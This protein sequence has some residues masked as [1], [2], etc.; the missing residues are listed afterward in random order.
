MGDEPPRATP[1]PRSELNTRSELTPPSPLAARN[2]WLHRGAASAAWSLAWLSI[3]AALI[4]RFAGPTPA[5]EGLPFYSSDVY[6]WL[7]VLVGAVNGPV[8]ALL[9]ARTFHPVAWISAACALGFSASA[10]CQSWAI[11][12]FATGNLPAVGFAA[13]A[14][15]WMWVAPAFASVLCLPW[16]LQPA[17]PGKSRRRIILAGAVTS[18]LLALSRLVL[19]DPSTSALPNPLSLA[20]APFYDAIV[21]AAIGLLVPA[22]VLGLAAMVH[23]IRQAAL[24]PARVRSAYR[25]VVVSLGLLLVTVMTVQLVSRATLGALFVV[26]VALLF[27]AQVLYPTAVIVLVLRSRLWGLDVTVSRL[28][29]WAVFTGLTVAC[30][31]ALLW[32][33]GMLLPTHGDV[34]Q[35]ASIAVLAVLLHPLRVH[36]QRTV[37]AMVYGP[38]SDPAVLIA[39]LGAQVEA[40]SG[41]SLITAVCNSLARGLSLESVELVLPAQS[42][43][44]AVST[45]SGRPVT[46]GTSQGSRVRETQVIEP[47]VLATLTPGRTMSLPL[48]LDAVDLGELRLTCRPGEHLDLRTHRLLRDVAP[49][50]AAAVHLAHLNEDLTM[51]RAQVVAVRDEERRLFR[52][53]IHDGVVPAFA[54]LALGIAGARRRL[55]R[56][57]QSARELLGE[58]EREASARARHAR[59][60]ARTVLPPQLDAGDLTGALTAFVER[61]ADGPVRVGIEI[62]DTVAC[63]NETSATAS[64]IT[65]YHVAVEAVTNA[66]RHARP[67]RV[68]IALVPRAESGIVLTVTDDGSGFDPKAAGGGIGM[69]SMR[70][71]ADAVGGRLAIASAPGAGSGTTVTLEIP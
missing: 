39:E 31:G 66:L 56:D 9:L 15:N 58:L 17:R 13:H 59:E 41:H 37:D 52:R 5:A 6:F 51:A 32:A 55:D 71:R 54:G 45:S 10:L 69:V 46:P 70:E 26:V 35:I 19:A 36:V 57:P 28:T 64:L 60:V 53:E 65:I 24:A 18:I 30:Y 20:D 34:V 50:I 3:T 62:A 68:D 38:A 22:A 12:G 63:G 11:Y 67:T 29:T 1:P 14:I 44:S 27:V 49:L 8:S 61:F 42:V 47:A 4:L 48:R 21:A 7:N 16:M 2:R 40:G 33:G 25:M 43:A 23:L